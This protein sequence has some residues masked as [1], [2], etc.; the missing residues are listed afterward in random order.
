MA[1]RTTDSRGRW[2]VLAMVAATGGAACSR[3]ADDGSFQTITGAL[4]QTTT[5]TITVPHG[6]DFTRL[7]VGAGNGI[8]AA[9][10][11]RVTAP[12]AVATGA[13]QINNDANV[14]TLT[15]GGNVNIGDRS[16]V[17]GDI[18]AGGTVQRAPSSVVTGTVRANF[19]F[20]APDQVLLAFT[21]DNVSQG[22]VNLAP[23]TTRDLPP[24]TYGDLTVNA[25]ARLTLHTGVYVF[26]R[27]TIEPGAIL[28]IDG[29]QGPVQVVLSGDF[30][31][32]GAVSAPS[33]VAQLLVAMTGAGTAL[34]E[35]PFTGVIV[36]PNA[37]I[38]LRAARAPGHQALFYGKTV[39]MEP[40]ISVRPH[41]FNWNALLGPPRI[42]PPVI[43]DPTR[44]IGNPAALPPG[45]HAQFPAHPGD[46]FLVT[47]PMVTVASAPPTS[48]VGTR[49][50]TPFLNAIRF[51]QGMGGLIAPA[52]G[53]AQP[54][55]N[56]NTLARSLEFDYFKNPGL[57]RPKTR[58]LLDVLLGLRPPSAV[59]DAAL[60]TGEGMNVSQFIAGIQRR[61]FDYPFKQRGAIFNGTPVP[62]EHTGLMAT[63][64]EEFDVDAIRGALYHRFA[65]GNTVRLTGGLCTEDPSVVKLAGAS[66]PSPC[67]AVEAA[68]AAIRVMSGIES[69]G[70]TPTEGP[71][72]VLLPSAN[73]PRG[74]LLRFAFRMTFRVKWRGQTGPALV[75]VDA[76]NGRIL[77]LDVMIHP[78]VA[79]TGTMYNRDPGI[80]TLATT[81]FDTFGMRVD[82]ATGDQYVLSLS[83]Y[84][85]RIQFQGDPASAS[86]VGIS[87]SS[88]GSSATLANFNQAPLNDPVQALCDSG[89]NKAFEQINFAATM[90][91]D[92]DDAVGLGAFTPIADTPFTPLLESPS[93]GCNAW[94]GL[95]FGI[96]PGYTNAACPDV[97]GEWLNTAH[98]GTWIGHELGHSVTPGFTNRRP[99][100]WCCDPA[101]TSCTVCPI[102][103]GWSNFHDLAD[104][105]SAHWE[106]TNCW[107]GWFGKNVGGVDAALGCAISDEG[108]GVPRLHT[109]TTPFNPALP[110]DHFPEHRAGNT[111]DYCDMQVASAALWQ[112]RAGMRSKCR[113]SGIPQY[114]VRFARALKDSGMLASLPP[115]TDAG[116]YRMMND[117]EAA[118]VR[119]WSTSGTANGP[120]AFAHNGAHTTNKVTAGFAKVG[121]F[122]VPNACLDGSGDPS[123]CPTAN[124][125]ADAVVDIFDNNAANDV[126][127]NEVAMEVND[128]LQLGGPVASF[129]VWTGSRFTFDASGAAVLANPSP[130]NARFQVDVSTDPAF[131]AGASTISSAFINVGT[132]TPTAAEWSALQTG[133]AGTKIY[134]RTRTQN[135][136]G[137]NE[138]QSNSPGNGLWTVPPPYAVFTA[139]GQ[140]DY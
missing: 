1:R 133:G 12:M 7:A 5:V 112:V 76:D 80:G 14:A 89:T 44:I 68:Q 138:R 137:G 135:G 117:L 65:V 121:F 53:V 84:F 120:P 21:A 119:Q 132:W 26:A 94:S 88:G 110:L 33:G 118:L 90:T 128:F 45:A 29:V 125:G 25:R 58:Y 83:G 69:V 16:R 96:C 79:A 98:D 122:L 17:N 10:R 24:G 64:W 81:G 136:S 139:D 107:S 140:S 48:S 134:Y 99:A 114:G 35:A 93:A 43:A 130:C 126:L 67:Q 101:D 57:L 66:G 82:P 28:S 104:A 124:N 78:A 87:A 4:I 41:P 18:T 103:V 72:L 9:D 27:A 59:A 86:N 111:C 50:I 6:T 129:R 54:V 63:R 97:P 85:N 13:L 116:V 115:N 55:A 34:V 19:A 70:N 52:A 20:G 42:E 32:R 74:V 56:F 40:D 105:W 51:T 3:G 49:F 30:T 11:V 91:R 73:D 2:C 75:W 47:L 92:L 60:Q 131:P 38:A 100:L 36:A 39:N 22:P 15:V 77:K 46:K 61:A 123:Q 23:D 127:V 108:G 62:I 8:T 71:S 31:F 109:V 37:S 113:P 106:S 95:N 102:P